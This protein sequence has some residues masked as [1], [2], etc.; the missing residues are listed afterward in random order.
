[1]TADWL[2][3]IKGEYQISAL[4]GSRVHP[5]TGQTSNHSGLD[6]SAKAGTAVLVTA[7][8]TVVQSAF[9][10]ELGNYI[11]VDHGDNRLTLYGCL[12]EALVSVSD[13]VNQGDIIGIVGQTGQATGP[14]LH[15]EVRDNNGDFYDPMDLYPDV[16]SGAK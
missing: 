15:L 11:L 10:Q 12:K 8:G 3:P 9:D 5:V 13:T 6:I 1:M 7:D 16:E 2:W 4:Y 14:H